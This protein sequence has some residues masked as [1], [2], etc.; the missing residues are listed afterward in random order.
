VSKFHYLGP[1]IIAKKDVPVR[2]KFTNNLSTGPDGDLF[3]PV[4][5][6]VMGAGMGPLDMMGMPG[7][8]PSTGWNRCSWGPPS[9]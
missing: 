3:I 7:I 2:I 4:D 9:G 5:Q 1:L 8:P 6:T